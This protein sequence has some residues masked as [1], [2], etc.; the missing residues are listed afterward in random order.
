[1]G[2]G[3][4]VDVVVGVGVGPGVGV[5]VGVWDGPGVAGGGQTSPGSGVAVGGAG[6]SG[7]GVGAAWGVRQPASSRVILVSSSHKNRLFRVCMVRPRNNDKKGLAEPFIALLQ[8]RP[9]FGMD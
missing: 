2:D 6:A 3:P 5:M 1:V 8:N 7:V 4:G 9:E